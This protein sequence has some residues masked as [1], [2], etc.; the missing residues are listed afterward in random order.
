M[1]CFQRFIDWL[2]NENI[3]DGE[4]SIIRDL[5]TIGII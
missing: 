4:K 2:N 1:T 3:P 5:N